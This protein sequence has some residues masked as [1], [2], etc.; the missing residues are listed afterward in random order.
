MNTKPPECWGTDAN[1]RALR[2]ELDAHH[3]LLLPFDQFVH[4]E[5]RQDT[6]EQQLR[7]VFGTHEV[8]IEGH[9]LRRIVAAL[10]R[11]DLAF[12]TPLPASARS[13][14]PDGQPAIRMITVTEVANEVPNPTPNP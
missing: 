10:Q 11:Q 2:V 1:A 3:S 6:G 8:L 12:V 7:A 13:A 9:A 14:I 4:A 5:W